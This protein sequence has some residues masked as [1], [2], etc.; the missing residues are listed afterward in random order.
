MNL[1]EEYSNCNLQGEYP[2]ARELLLRSADGF[3]LLYDITNT[4]ASNLEKMIEENLKQ[5]HHVK[6]VNKF[7]VV[8]VGTKCDLEFDRKIDFE[9]GESL[10]NE[11]NIPFFETSAKIPFNIEESLFALV[12]EISKTQKFFTHDKKNEKECL[13]M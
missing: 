10:A 11:F 3:L 5:I 12:E 13:L 2:G 9:S 7:P 1:I 4:T 6:E 8:L